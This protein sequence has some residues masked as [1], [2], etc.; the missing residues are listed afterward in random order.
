MLQVWRRSYRGDPLYKDLASHA[1]AVRVVC[2]QLLE[3]RRPSA[4]CPW[5]VAKRGVHDQALRS[6]GRTALA[7]PVLVRPVAGTPK[8]A[9]APVPRGVWRRCAVSCGVLRCLAMSRGVPRCPAVFRNVPRRPTVFHDVLRCSAVLGGARRHPAVSRVVW[10]CCVSSGVV[11]QSRGVVWWVALLC[12]VPLC[13]LL[14]VVV[15]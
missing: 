15:Q 11:L 4:R 3:S 9:P 8:T 5:G 7:P 1:A 12:V 13:V 6:A 10:R 14:R 2:R